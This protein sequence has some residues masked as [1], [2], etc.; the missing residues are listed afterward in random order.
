MICITRSGISIGSAKK[1][2]PTKMTIKHNRM[3]VL[4]KGRPVPNLLNNK[5]EKEMWNYKCYSWR[6]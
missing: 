6:K 2:A 5:T 1:A 4:Q 3:V